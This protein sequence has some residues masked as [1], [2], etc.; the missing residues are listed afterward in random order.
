LE[1]IFF[2]FNHGIWQLKKVNFDQSCILIFFLTFKS[3]KNVT[4]TLA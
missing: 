1:N 2:P 3:V 4:E